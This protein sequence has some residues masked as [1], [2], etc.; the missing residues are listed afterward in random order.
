MDSRI[1]YSTPFFVAA[2][3][4]FVVALF[5]Y[6]RR[7]ARG[8]WY[9]TLVCLSASV[10]A[11]SE[12]M[13]YF[14]LDIESNMLITNLQYFGI[15]PL[16]PLALLFGLSIFGFES[17]INRRRLFFFFFIAIIIIILVWTNPIHKLIFTD[18]YTI[19]SGPFPMLGLKHGP[20]WWI[21]LVYQ[22]SLIAVLTIVL[23]FEVLTCVSFHRAQAGLILVAVTVVWGFNAIYA[24]GNSPVPNIDIS[25]IAFTLVAASMAWG[26]FRYNLLD[27]LPIAKSEIF[28]GLD[29]AILVFDRKD[30]I[31]DIN[32]TA[33]SM[34]GIGVAEAIG[35][36]D[37]QFSGDHPQLHRLLDEMKQNEVRLIIE[38]Q[39]RVYDI[40][41]SVLKDK[42][43]VLLGRMIVL[44]NISDRKCMEDA[45][46]Q[47]EAR[48]KDISYSMADWIWETDSNGKYTFTSGRVKEILGYPPE[49]LIG[50]TPFDLMP[51]DEAKRIEEVFKRIASEKI[52]II[53]LEN[54]NLT[55]KGKKI[56]LLTNGVPMLD[57]R[58]VFIGYRGVDKDITEA[59][60]AEEERAK[61][62]NQLQQARKMETIG[63]LAGGVAHDLN[64]ILSGIVSYPELILMD[65]PEGSP[66]RKAILT[67]KSSGE[68]AAVVVQ[69]LLTLARRGVSITETVNLNRIISEQ[70]KSPEYEK[71]KS[72][73]PNAEVKTNLNKDLLNIKGSTTHL[74]KTVMNLVSNAAEAMPDGGKISISTENLYIDKPINGYD[75]I[76]KGDYV[77]FKI[78]DT[79]IGIS[80]EDM[81]RIFEPFY[82]KKVMGRSGTG[83]GMA[84]VWGTVKDH[85]GYIDIQSTPGK[86]TTFTLYFPVT[87][88]EIDGQEKALPI[89]KYMGKGEPILVVDD[90][91]EQR[92]IASRILNKL[93][94]SV[95]SVSSGEEA[96]EYIKGNSVDLLVLDMIMDPGIDGLETYKRI[97]K[98]HS[99]QK[100][101]IASGFSETERVK[102]AQRMGAGKYIKKPYTLEKI[103]I[104]VKEELGE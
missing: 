7:K 58:G 50:Q 84:V 90:V 23:L 3:L 82:T 38:G 80:K 43:G 42:K 41:S 102:E 85:K 16:P 66:L 55:K 20:L 63:I 97:L 56:C 15:T 73:H 51:E 62:Q 64:N 33:E 78:S 91:E 28:C 39:E 47:S 53:D 12:G 32:P 30:R 13:L 37:L 81:E 98:L 70:L 4:I 72:F 65:L 19:D 11:T 92:E 2:I 99:N 83:L 18:Y 75:H 48:F 94:Y 86:G 14:G 10:W 100:A 87:R 40:H 31:I 59:K 22:Y 34:F 61:L 101:I 71:L 54:W 95:T 44:R 26:F 68:K 27:I 88:K 57:K 45:L 35:Q 21:I 77:T 104:A 36:G 93:G 60:L 29:D 103:G 5:V 24:S 74:S 1:I 17:L 79:G 46:R 76:D 49:E 8:A 89:E 52:P 69:D 67:I 25:S 6:S 96:V 9:L